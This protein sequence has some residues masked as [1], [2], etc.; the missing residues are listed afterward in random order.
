MNTA[1]SPEVH[2]SVAPGFE[3][4]RE[5]FADGFQGRPGMGAAVAVHHQ[6]RPV[7]DLWAGVKDAR[8]GSAWEEDTATVIFSVTKGL[9]SVLVA[10]LVDQGLIDYDAPLAEYWPEFAANGK[11]R[12]TVREALGHRAGLSAVRVPLSKE[13]ML[14]WDFMTSLLA[15]QEPLWE[16]GSAYAYHSITHGW[17][18]GELIRRVTGQTPGRHF[19]EVFGPVTSEAWLGLPEAETGRVA[20]I[21]LSEAYEQSSRDRLRLPNQ[22]AARGPEMGGAL[23]PE[24]VG[25]HTGANDP[26]FHAAEF[27]AAG[28]ITTARGLAAIWSAVVHEGEEGPLLRA[29]T[30]VDGLRVVS[31]GPQALEIPGP[32]VDRFTAGFQRPGEGQDLLSPEGFGHYGAGGQLGFADPAYDVGFG[33]LSNWMEPDAE[34][35]SAV[36]AAVRESITAR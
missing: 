28:G 29:E 32:W 3:K 8:S 16:P 6:G 10:R 12:L 35:A 23:P 1:S 36:V 13:Q 14:D 7:V 27:P 31:E 25:E 9:A 11:G 33:Y 21:A 15:E 19:A 34:R 20:Q 17:L 30:L 5:A 4:V 2:G 26:L 22:F 24:L 18:S